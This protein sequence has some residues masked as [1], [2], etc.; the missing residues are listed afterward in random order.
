[1][2]V[3]ERGFAYAKAQETRSSAKKK[4]IEKTKHHVRKDD[5]VRDVGA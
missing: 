5:H 1:M 3:I 2:L 4:I